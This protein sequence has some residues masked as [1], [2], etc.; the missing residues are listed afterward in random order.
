M[1][2]Q[3]KQDIAG[4]GGDAKFVKTSGDARYYYPLTDDP[5]ADGSRA[6]RLYVWL[7]GGEKIS[8][9]SRSVQPRPGSRARL[10]AWRHR[11]SKICPGGA[12]GN[13]LGGTTYVGGTLEFCSRSSAFLAKSVCAVPSL[14]T[15]V[16]SLVMAARCIASSADRLRPP[17]RPGTGNCLT[18]QGAGQEVVFV[19]SIL[20]DFDF[21]RSARRSAPA[22]CCGLHQFGPLRFDYA[23]VLTKT[24]HDDTQAFHFGTIVNY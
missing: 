4:L 15:R 24:K 16:R 5:D 11:S 9:Q 17:I 21:T 22:P 14:P 12:K 8:D 23:F 1:Y 10:C 13:G 18:S 20:V 19:R 3:F 6:R 7:F 2:A